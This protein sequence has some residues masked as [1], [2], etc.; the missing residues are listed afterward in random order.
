MI[1]FKAFEIWIKALTSGK[2]KR[3]RAALR[4]DSGYCCLGVAT[5]EY[6][7]RKGGEWKVQTNVLNDENLYSFE[8]R[9][10]FLPACVQD[11]LGISER[12]ITINYCSLSD[13]NDKGVSFKKIAALLTTFV[14]HQRD[15]AEKQ[16][17]LASKRKRT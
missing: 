2:Y 9:G 8:G 17:A 7:K 3:A 16:K 15:M 6:R 10:D 13:R 12:D 4:T 14:K 5:E 11:W 1:N